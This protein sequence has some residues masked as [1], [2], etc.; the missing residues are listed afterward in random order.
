MCKSKIR[1]I[2]LSLIVLLF[3]LVSCGGKAVKKE[4]PYDPQG[5]ISR[6]EEDISK[7]EYAEARKLLLE[8]KNRDT[9]KNFAPTAQLKIADSYIKDGEFDSGIDEYRKFIEL[10]PDN[11]YA[12][13]AQYQ[14]GMAYFN[15]IE[16]PDR[17]SGEAKKALQEFIKAKE[18]YPRSPYKEAIELRIEKC[19]NIMADSEFMVGEY[20]Y[21]K[22]SFSAAAGRFEY[23]LKTY[24]NYKGEDETLFLLGK[25]Y[26]ALL[27]K[28]KAEEFLKILIEKYPSSK[29]AFE[30][31]KGFR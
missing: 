27:N 1:W 3:L 11:Q 24:P 12:Y 29:Y 6:A 20:Y 28:E 23:L 15:Q 22:G 14:I 10:Y 19:K 16:S 21:K 17:G 30:A 26:S 9:T 4:E 5:N 13:Y 8:V 2:A 7:E 31:K 25:C 18:R